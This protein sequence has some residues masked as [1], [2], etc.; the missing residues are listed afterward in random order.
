[1]HLLN[2]IKLKEGHLHLPEDLGHLLWALRAGLKRWRLLLAK[3]VHHHHLRVRQFFK[4]GFN[5]S[6]NR[7]IVASIKW[8]DE[9]F[10][11]IIKI[12]WSKMIVTTFIYRRRSRSSN[13]FKWRKW[14]YKRRWQKIQQIAITSRKCNSWTQIRPSRSNPKFKSGTGSD[15]QT[16]QGSP[17]RLETFRQRLW[18]KSIL[19]RALQ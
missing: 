12:L 1:M 3:M 14:G 13:S 19:W 10:H 7:Q 4:N 8:F 16:K 11:L 17:W 18:T 9:F 5:W 2:L 15:N 6:K